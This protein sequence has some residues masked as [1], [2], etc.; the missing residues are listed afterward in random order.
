MDG[1]S[2]SSCLLTCFFPK[3]GDV[4]H[5]FLPG[6]HMPPVLIGEQGPSFGGLEP[7]E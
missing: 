1:I 7:Q 3:V 4:K 6:N 5:P 2:R